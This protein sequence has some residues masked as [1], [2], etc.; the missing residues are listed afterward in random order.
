MIHT[1]FDIRDRAKSNLSEYVWDYIEG[2]AGSET[3]MQRNSNDFNRY[4]ITPRVLRDVSDPDTSITIFNKRYNLPI[5][6]A[7]VSPLRLIGEDA[8]FNQAKA[9]KDFD[10]V[11]VCSTNTHHSMSEIATFSGENLWFQLFPF[12]GRDWI[13]MIISNAETLGF[14][15]IVLTVDAFY[16]ALRERMMRQNYT[17]PTYICMGNLKEIDESGVKKTKGW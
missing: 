8:E 11:S 9:A 16:P 15:A 14:E 4:V 5:M 7:P 1:I 6:L 3:T 2:G 12:A 10:I 13:E 17:H